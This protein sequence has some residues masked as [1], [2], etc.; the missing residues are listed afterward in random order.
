MADNRRDI[1]LR[2]KANDQSEAGLKGVAAN[3]GK[4]TSELDRQA[5]AALKAAEANAETYNAADKSLKKAQES[6]LEARKAYE[7]FYDTLADVASPTNKQSREFDKLGRAADKADT[8]VAKLQRTLEKAEAGFTT[9]IA[10][11]EAAQKA[12]VERRAAEQGSLRFAGALEEGQGQEAARAAAERRAAEISSLKLS[13]AIEEAQRAQETAARLSV[14]RKTGDDAL[15]AVPGLNAYTGA[16]GAVSNAVEGLAGDLR[17]LIDPTGAARATLDGLEGEV[18][19]LGAIIGEADKPIRDYQEAIYDLGA[20]QAQILKQ[21]G[22]VDAYKQQ[23]VVVD[24]AAAA[25][26]SARAEV[27]RYAE[28]IRSADALNEELTNSLRQAEAA[29]ESTGAALDR[30]AAKLAK[31]KQPLDAAKISTNDLAGAETRLKVAA[32][33]TAGATAKLDKAM[34]GQNSK[35]GRFLG[36]RPYEI[37]NLG[38]QLNDVFTQIASGTSITQTFAQQSGQIFQIFPGLFSRIVSFAPQLLA[39]TLVAG[40]AFAA[41]KKLTEE[42]ASVR[43]FSGTLALNADGARLNADALAETAHNLDVYGASLKDA[44]TE[45]KTF[46]S[47]G[48]DPSLFERYGLAADKLAKTLGIEL[49]DAAKQLAVAFT[50]GWEQVKALDDATNFLTATQAES[51]EQMFKEGRATEARTAAFAALEAKLDIVAEKSE[52]PWTQ[53]G[54][55]LGDIW[56]SFLTIISNLKPIQDFIVQLNEF[57]AA[58]KEAAKWMAELSNPQKMRIP[59]TPKTAAERTPDQ[60]PLAERVVR[61]FQPS[62]DVSNAFGGTPRRQQARPAQAAQA[63][64]ALAP[65][66]QQIKDAGA[67]T[68]AYKDQQDALTGLTRAQK[69]AVAARRLLKAEEDAALKGAAKNLTDQQIAELKLTARKTEQLKIDREQAAQN[70]AD[71]KKGETAARKA[72]AAARRASAAARAEQAKR[73]SLEG[74]LVNDLGA[75]DAKIARQQKTSLEERLSAVDSAYAK[76]YDRIDKLQAA[77]GKDVNGVSLDKVRAQVELN[78]QLLKQQDTLVYYEDAMAALEDRRD[79]KLKSITDQQASGS[80]SSA[81][82]FRQALAATT[83]LNPQMAD[84]AASAKEFAIGVIGA[85]ALNGIEPSPALLAFV[86]QMNAAEANAR[87]PNAQNSQAAKVGQE[88]IAVREKE[89]NAALAER[90][91]LIQVAQQLQEKGAITAEEE[92]RRIKAAYDETGAGIRTQIQASREL[93]EAMRASGALT[94]TQ[95]KALSGQLDVT[96][97]QLDYTD[98]RLLEL[99]QIAQDSIVN[100]IMGAFES[101][102]NSIAGLIDNTKSWGDAIK[103]LWD[104]TKSFFASFLA[105]VAKAIV[106]TLALA[107]A[108]QIL[109]AFSGGGG[110]GKFVSSIGQALVKHDGGGVGAYGRK[111]QIRIS[112]FANVPRYHDGRV[113]I[114]LGPNEHRAILETGETVLSK[115]DPDNP[116]NGGPRRASAPAPQ[117]NLKVVNLFDKEAAAAEMLNTRAGERAIL[118]VIDNNPSAIQKVTS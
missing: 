55:S 64:K 98:E 117:L 56:D 114:G 3:I 33:A 93:Y 48:L 41:I 15:A 53:A 107:A 19:R 95:F 72:E 70:L 11:Y 110:V 116:V 6:A 85:N 91:Q 31:L 13:A 108:Q 86:E 57:A 18:T 9:G 26:E 21:A 29:L 92:R 38:Y 50:G 17:T 45:I 112:D 102:A 104:T 34:A 8:E 36:L 49:P 60:V 66:Q 100:G 24:Q 109:N 62:N 52:G 4:V 10:K 20:A 75:M 32:E 42:E 101:A 78:K 40:T 87:K 28:T 118:N 16:T 84:L 12:A 63:I 43:Q 83:A 46:I 105:S 47:Q 30:E 65:T 1:E 106:Q 82:A 44:R 77:G 23:K 69:L 99:K 25:Y 111:R 35:T 5:K 74:Q 80:I 68:E 113:G 97:S 71:Q 2:I 94:E 96:N 39:I 73:D 89:L 14:F 59:K 61:F 81:E 22:F 37:Q 58:A 103:D 115:D 76:I 7:A 67:L 51:I 88:Q 27:V 79:A 54:R 90:A